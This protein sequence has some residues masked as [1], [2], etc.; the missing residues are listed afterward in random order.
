[1]FAVP[2]TMVCGI[3]SIVLRTK[4]LKRVFYPLR[5]RTDTLFLQNSLAI[6]YCTTMR[7]YLY[8]LFLQEMEIWLCLTL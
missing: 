6:S 2:K 1:M 3:V 5:L 8:F 7:A 4:R